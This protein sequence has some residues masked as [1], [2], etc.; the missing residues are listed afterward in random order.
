[1][2]F[3]WVNGSEHTHIQ[4]FQKITGHNLT[5]KERI[6]LAEYGTLRFAL[7]SVDKNMPFFRK[8]HLV[9]NGQVPSWWNKNNPKAQIVTHNQIFL[10][11][12][13][14]GETVLLEDALPT[15]NSNAIECSLHNIPGLAKFVALFND[16]V[17][18]T[19]PMTIND[20][21]NTSTGLLQLNI[22]DLPLINNISGHWAKSLKF[23]GT[24]L[25][26]K[27]HPKKPHFF[28]CH[29]CYVFDRDVLKF[30]AQTWPNETK[31]TMMHKTR[32]TNDM[33]LAAMMANVALEEHLGMVTNRIG[34]NMYPW[35]CKESHNQKVWNQFLNDKGKSA[36]IQDEMKCTDRARFERDLNEKLC[37]LF[38][39]RSSF[40][41]PAS[42]N[43]CD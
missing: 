19:R 25:K 32:K 15:F 18:A 43:P 37:M 26:Q 42:T 6:R 1:M 34:G 38:P 10:T 27:Y 36:C 22:G 23:T 33:V 21:V 17:F 7:R 28:P 5:K 40:E 31:Q 14:Q 39:E 9:T 41:D 3:T 12:N 20:F 2:V 35:R 30:I 29:A 24:L 16:D 13:K 8:L 11:N 4:L